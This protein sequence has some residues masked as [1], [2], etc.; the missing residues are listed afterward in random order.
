[1]VNKRLA[2]ASTD[3][4]GYF[5]IKLPSDFKDKN[6]TLTITYIG[7][8]PLYSSVGLSNNQSLNLELCA[9]GEIMGDVVVSRAPFWKRVYFKM[10]NQLRGVNPFYTN[11]K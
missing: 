8:K 2:F 6:C 1:M 5:E 7:Y 9:S 3:Q 11:K 10:R 4:K